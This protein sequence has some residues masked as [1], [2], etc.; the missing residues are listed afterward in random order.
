MPS[1]FNPF[2]HSAVITV[3]AGAS[4][5]KVFSKSSLVCSFIHSFIPACDHPPTPASIFL[6]IYF[7]CIN[8]LPEY[9]SVYHV[10]I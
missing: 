7:V 4:E 5:V 2:N 10:C 9:M 6:K 1:L 8:A 3:I